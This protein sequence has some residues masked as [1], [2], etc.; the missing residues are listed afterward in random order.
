MMRWEKNSVNKGITFCTRRNTTHLP[1]SSSPTQLMSQ[2]ISNIL[3]ICYL[4]D[5]FLILTGMEPLSLCSGS[6]LTQVSLKRLDARETLLALWVCV[7]GACIRSS[8][9]WSFLMSVWPSWTILWWRLSQIRKICGNS[10]ELMP[11]SFS[12]MMSVFP[13][14]SISGHYSSIG[15]TEW[16]DLRRKR[17]I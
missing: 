3:A 1:T 8:M 12:L 5:I 4:I 16:L 10:T 2:L 6:C 7:S 13:S 9:L 11:G 17:K 14:P 15:S